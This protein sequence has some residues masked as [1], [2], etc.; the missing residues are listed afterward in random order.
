MVPSQLNVPTYAALLPREVWGMIGQPFTYV[1]E[2]LPLNAL[3][4]VAFDTQ[5]QQDSD[6]LIVHATGSVTATDNQTNTAFLPALIQVVDA[7]SGRQ[8]Y[9]RPAQIHAAI[10]LGAAS[11]QL[12]FYWPMPWL[13]DRG[14]TITTTIQ[15]LFAATNANVRLCYNGVKLFGDRAKIRQSLIAAGILP[16]D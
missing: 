5:I 7:G 8:L 1:A 13:I 15:S 4:T 9:S 14:S 16:A 6:F 10:S 12:P 2:F 3:T 11:A